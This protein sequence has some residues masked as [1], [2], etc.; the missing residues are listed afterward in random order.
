[1]PQLNEVWKDQEGTFYTPAYE[2]DHEERKYKVKQFYWFAF[3]TAEPIH[4]SNKLMKT[5]LVKIFEKDGTYVG[6]N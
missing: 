5:P 4:E 2:F 6:D 3:A 1:M